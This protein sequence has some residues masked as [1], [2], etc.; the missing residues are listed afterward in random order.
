[1]S[2]RCSIQPCLRVCSV[3]DP[4][5]SPCLLGVRSSPVSVSARC[6]IQPS[7]LM[8]VRYLTLVLPRVSLYINTAPPPCDGRLRRLRR[9]TASLVM[10]KTAS[11]DR[12]CRLANLAAPTPSSWPTSAYQDSRS[13]PPTAVHRCSRRTHARVERAVHRRCRRTRAQSAAAAC[14]RT[15]AL[16][17][18]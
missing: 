5:L 18:R 15:D 12:Q 10:L 11:E 17:R 1:M 16:C 2:A 8:S 13:L 7:L 14:A 3:F 9:W 6:S 4:A